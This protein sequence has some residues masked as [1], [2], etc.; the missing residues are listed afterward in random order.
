MPTATLTFNLPEE[1]QEHQTAVRAPDVKFG[2]QEYDN[3]LRSK[4]KYHDETEWEGKSAY[5][6]LVEA[7]RMLREYV[8]EYDVFE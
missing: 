3:W 1:N 8:G 4:T 5:D 2:I 7:R 6:V